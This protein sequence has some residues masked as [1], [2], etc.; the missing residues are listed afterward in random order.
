MNEEAQIK[1]EE[2]SVSVCC[3]KRD[4][5]KPRVRLC[6]SLAKLPSAATAASSA[7]VPQGST[8]P[9]SPN[10]KDHCPAVAANKMGPGGSSTLRSGWGGVG[11]LW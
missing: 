9:S 8:Y 1:E 10:D 2:Q 3:L 6:V 7:E 11:G 5:S 4:R